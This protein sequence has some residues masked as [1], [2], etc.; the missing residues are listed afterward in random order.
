MLVF[1]KGAIIRTHTPRAPMKTI[2]RLLS[3]IF[4]LKSLIF[5]ELEILKFRLNLCRQ[6]EPDF[7]EVNYM[8]HIAFI[9]VIGL[10]ESRLR[11]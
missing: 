8:F 1:M 7:I 9:I 4:S 2:A 3:K 5:R 11:M 6:T 10:W